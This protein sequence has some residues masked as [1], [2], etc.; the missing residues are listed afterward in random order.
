MVRFFAV[1][2]LA[3]LSAYPPVARAQEREVPSAA[4]LLQAERAAPGIP[5]RV[6]QWSEAKECLS[7]HGINDK[8]V[9]ISPHP[10]RLACTQCHVPMEF[11]APQPRKPARK[12]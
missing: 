2:A 6:G 1:A 8:G 5:H 7:C 11:S 12:R 10:V 9:P 4:E 3:I